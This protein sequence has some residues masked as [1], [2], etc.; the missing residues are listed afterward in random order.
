[1]TIEEIKALAMIYDLTRIGRDGGICGSVLQNN[2]LLHLY[3]AAHAIL[4]TFDWPRQENPNKDEQ[5]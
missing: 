4:E 5:A 2:H 3:G 1:M